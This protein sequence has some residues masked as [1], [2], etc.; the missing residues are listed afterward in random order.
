MTVRQGWSRMRR[1]GTRRAATGLVTGSFL[2]VASLGLFETGAGATSDSSQAASLAQARK[3][4][5]VLSDMP[6][7]WTSTKN[8]NANN[9]SSLGNKQLAHCI[10]VS[11]S[12]IAENPPSVYSPQFQNSDGTLTVADSVAVFPSTKN[13]TAEYAV[14]SN[15]KFPSCLTALASGPLKAKLFGKLPKGTTIGTPLVSA[16]AATAL[17][18]GVAGYSLS[19]PVTAQGVTLNV[20]VTQLVTIKGRLGHQV[21]FTS[22][23]TPFSLAVE[24]QIMKVAAA[25][26]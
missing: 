23:G 12:L 13:A 6:A 24:Q 22:A 26:L 15:P 20:T 21:T 7:G 18:P 10:G 4:L 17:A 11:S 3:D 9:N 25:R 16:V 19:V 14:G 8:P 2:L 5:L 1:A